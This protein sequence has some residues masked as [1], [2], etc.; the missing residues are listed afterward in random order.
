M[1]FLIRELNWYPTLAR[2]FSACSIGILSFL[3]HKSFSFK[4]RKP[5]NPKE[6]INLL[7]IPDEEDIR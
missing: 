2:T 1:T 4:I 5:D 7:E 3:I 6:E